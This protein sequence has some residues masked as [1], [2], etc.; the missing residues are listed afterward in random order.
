[1]AKVLT[2]KDATQQ[3]VDSEHSPSNLDGLT[4]VNPSFFGLLVKLS[5]FV[6]ET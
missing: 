3:S 5:R 2:G 6:I 1:M 4:L